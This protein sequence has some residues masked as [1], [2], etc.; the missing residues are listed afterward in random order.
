MAFLSPWMLFGALAAGIP[1][2]LHFFY[3]SRFRVVPWAA[4][5]FLLA[6]IQQTSRRLKFQELLLLVLRCVLLV[7]LAVALARPALRAVGIGRG[8]SI[9]AVLVFDVSGSMAAREGP[10]TRLD[11]AKASALQVLDQLPPSS[12][13]Q[14]VTCADRAT[15]LGPHSPSNLDQ[16][17][18]LIQAIQPTELA[19]DLLPGVIEAAGALERGHSPNREV[20]L[21]SDMQ[22]RGWEQQSMALRS[23]LQEIHE[24]AE[25]YMVR[26][27]TRMIRNAAIVGL[28]GQSGLPHVG[29]RTTFA[30]LVRNTGTAALHNL[31]V[32]LEVD[33]RV[34]D[35]DSQLLPLLGPGE[36]QP[37]P[38]TARLLRPGQQVV[39]ATVGPDDLDGDNRFEQIIQVR[40]QVRVLVV[41]G[42]PNEGDPVKSASF[43]LLTALQ[44]VPEEN[45]ADYFIQPRVTIPRLAAPLQLA[46]KDL[47]IL[48][49][50]PLRPSVSNEAGHLSTGFLERL[51]K[52]VREGHGLLIFAGPHVEPE[53]YNQVLEEKYGLLPLHL[54]K[55]I[56]MQGKM[57]LNPD[58]GSADSYSFLG[59][60]RDAPLNKLGLV[61]VR[62]ALDGGPLS[63]T[64]GRIDLCYTNGKPALASR[65]VGRGQVLL[66]TTTSDPRWTDLPLWPVY[67]PLVHSA[68]GHLL[69][70]N[71][72]AQN[73]VVG[74][75]FTW[76]PPF[77]D[78]TR[79]H[80]LTTP[81]GEEVDL[82]F[83]RQ[84]EGHAFLTVA[85]TSRAGIY[86]IRPVVPGER[87]EPITRPEPEHPK[88]MAD[89]VF[90][91]NADLR[92]TE[93][94][95][96]LN[97]REL[98]DQAGIP[99]FHLTA[100]Q[101]EPGGALDLGVGSNRLNREW[102]AWLLGL[103]LAL[104]VCETALAWFCGRSW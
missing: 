91:V 80:R 98:D 46:D 44:P 4:M 58:V 48:V 49:D 40:D 24:K 68:V 34:A 33:G 45:K 73:R 13:V 23:R 103:V 28:V 43:H 78:E 56:T 41:D 16:A 1:L 15:L 77:R 90:A 39:T 66:C 7:L 17:R 55:S 2:A 35:R 38:L 9:D 101:A 37:V 71:V 30:V 59:A 70:G 53:A 57:Q 94:L 25:V 32:T 14:I 100:G 11:L 6:S 27:G 67:L 64:A 88:D 75:P 52:F 54:G 42:S 72:L 62:Q 36:T 95:G 93:D 61:D 8:E 83:P 87:D 102:T 99:L 76:S 18:N 5:E 21:F 82:G 29:E 50:V 19:T 86:R 47:C 20:Y 81:L 31:T 92:E 96:T 84:E 63:S 69:Q 97:D 22:K 26:C 104:V 65:T 3:R 79:S 85:D 74:Q 10:T 60:F 51:A 89:G 12:T